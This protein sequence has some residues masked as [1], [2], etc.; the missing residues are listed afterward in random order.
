MVI[1]I[2]ILWSVTDMVIIIVINYD[3]NK[4]KN[5]SVTNMFIIILTNMDNDKNNNN[6]NDNSNDDMK[7]LYIYIITMRMIDT[8][9]LM[10]H[11]R[12]SAHQQ[13]NLARSNGPV[14]ARSKVV[15]QITSISIEWPGFLRDVS[16]WSRYSIDGIWC[17][18][19]I[20]CIW[21]YMMVYDGIWWYIM[22]TW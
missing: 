14:L 15:K 13:P 8:E 7:Q 20:W 5:N 17:I 18:W 9:L 22:G 2:I 21:W 10:A 19:C 6:A 12:T 11:E 1:I 3:D 4:N 16:Y